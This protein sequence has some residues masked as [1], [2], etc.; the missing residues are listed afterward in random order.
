MPRV[1]PSQG[2]PASG[3]K[4]G[5][6][7]TTPAALGMR[8]PGPH[9]AILTDGCRK[10]FPSGRDQHLLTMGRVFPHRQRQDRHHRHPCRER[11]L[12]EIRIA[13]DNHQQQ[14]QPVPRTAVVRIVHQVE[15]GSLDVPAYTSR[16]N[17]TEPRNNENKKGLRLQILSQGC[18]HPRDPLQYQEATR[19]NHG[20]HPQHAAPE[21]HDRLTP[22]RRG[23]GNALTRLHNTR[24]RCYQLDPLTSRPP[25]PSKWVTAST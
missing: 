19:H 15:C 6:P 14:R 21:S 20:A 22:T 17:P 3:P 16:A 23:H 1:L 8:W 10:T 12:H 25:Q 9:A 2:C 24:R 13:K 18:T 5:G 4:T 7:A 11:G